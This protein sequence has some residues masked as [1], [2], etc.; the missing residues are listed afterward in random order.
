MSLSGRNRSE[1]DFT[2]IRNL[3]DLSS[4]KDSLHNAL[5]ELIFSLISTVCSPTFNFIASITLS[6]LF[7]FKL[8]DVI[9]K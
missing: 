7:I 1:D 3:L 6:Y 2:Y 4:A 5:P 9:Y 8:I